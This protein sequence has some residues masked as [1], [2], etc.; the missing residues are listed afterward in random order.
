MAERSRC[1]GPD[2]LR[3]GPGAVV[4]VRL[5]YAALQRGYLEQTEICEVPGIGPIPLQAAREFLGDSY[6]MGILIQGEDIRSVKG[7]GHSIP[8]RLRRAVFERDNFRF[9]RYRP[10]SYP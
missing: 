10:G 9:T 3:P 4:H 2:A 5:D 1:T 8:D 6:R 7:L